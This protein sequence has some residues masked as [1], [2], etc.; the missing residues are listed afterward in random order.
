MR[1]AF[2]TLAAAS[3]IA[4]YAAA[5]A[6]SVDVG[7]ARFVTRIESTTEPLVLK[8]SGILRWKALIRAYAA[9]LYLPSDVS[10]ESA[11]D[12]VPKRL[13]IEYFWAIEGPDFGRAA[14][15]L[16]GDRLGSE[17]VA[18]L[19]TRLDALHQSYE[20]VEPGDRYALT[21]R[22]GVGTELSKNGRSLTVIPGS[23]F[24]SAYF[25]LWLGDQPIDSRLRDDL[26]GGTSQRA[27]TE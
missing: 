16:L 10:T 6:A 12:D 2:L 5:A 22:P 7:G 9:A 4:V 15:R 13:E 21:Y 25:G 24:A 18:P 14:D 17:G 20:S 1:L 3:S 26:R 11:L 23:D 8:G 19:R 27:R